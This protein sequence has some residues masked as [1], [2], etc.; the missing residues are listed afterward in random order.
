MEAHKEA[1]HISRL[2]SITGLLLV[3]TRHCM[4]VLIVCAMNHSN[5]S[6]LYFLAN[7]SA[8]FFVYSLPGMHPPAL[9][10]SCWSCVD[11][12]GMNVSVLYV[13]NAEKHWC[14]AERP[15]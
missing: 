1:L 3:E 15:F 4:C 8:L 2:L 10:L 12:C 6:E 9:L 14:L 13:C 11:A 5:I 7:Q